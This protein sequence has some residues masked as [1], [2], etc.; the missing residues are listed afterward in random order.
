MIKLNDFHEIRVTLTG[1]A[2]L[3][4]SD[5]A[6]SGHLRN[7]A[8]PRSNLSSSRRFSGGAR[9]DQLSVPRCCP[10]FCPAPLWPNKSG[11]ST[12]ATTTCSC[13]WFYRCVYLISCPWFLSD[14][15]L[16]LKYVHW[17]TWLAISALSM[18]SQMSGRKTILCS[19]HWTSL[20]ISWIKVMVTEW[21]SGNVSSAT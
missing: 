5:L 17:I 15:T 7:V 14:P 6:L 21:K 3:I 10:I 13:S 1:F 19:E 18:S 2:T 9:G 12:H 20:S 8:H 4:S 16:C 11:N